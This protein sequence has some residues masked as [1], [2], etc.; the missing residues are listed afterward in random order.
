M[1]IPTTSSLVWIPSF[2]LDF[3]VKF[4]GKTKSRFLLDF[5]LVRLSCQEN[6]IS[7][8]LKLESF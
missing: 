4:E 1:I 5:V 6:K 7:P 3:K 8:Y 2:G